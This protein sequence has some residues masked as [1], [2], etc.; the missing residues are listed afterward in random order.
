M[1]N[2]AAEEMKNHV[3]FENT[4]MEAIV[5][6]VKSN[7][8][9]IKPEERLTAGD[10]HKALQAILSTAQKDLSPF[11]KEVDQTLPV[12]PIFSQPAQRVNIPA[13]YDQR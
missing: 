4:A 9:I 13:T 10:T 12:P 3:W 2:E 7:L 11:T 1:V 5:K 8:L 6:L